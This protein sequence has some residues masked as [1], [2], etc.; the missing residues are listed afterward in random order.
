[1]S[2][3]AAAADTAD[4]TEA[5]GG[6]KKLIIIIAAA[7]AI[8]LVAGGL[9]MKMMMAPKETPKDPAKEKGAVVALKDDMTLNLADGRFLKTQLSLQLSEEATLAAG[10]EK[11]L[12]NFDGSMA[13]DA[14][15]QI[16]SRYS[17][18]QLL[19]PAQREAAQV[20]LSKEVFERY[21]GKVLQVYF[22]QFVMQ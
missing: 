13:R 9:M 2:A 4:G 3:V 14:A 5:K 18:N 20:A 8:V 6:S 10:G 11:A 22:T 7:V 19:K 16:L 17:Y 21:E 12:A 15:I 1:M